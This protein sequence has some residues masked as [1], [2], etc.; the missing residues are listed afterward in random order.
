MS[1]EDTAPSVRA[2]T[3]TATSW[4]VKG[5]DVYFYFEAR[6]YRIRGLSSNHSLQQLRVNVLVRRDE[7]VH[8]DTF[9]L[10]KA[11][12]RASFI[13][14]VASELYA[15]EETIKRELGPILLQLEQLQLDQIEAA[16]AT[17]QVRIE[18]TDKQRR[19]AL[20]LLR[21]SRLT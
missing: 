2:E 4:E 5:E 17:E 10:Y 7:L 16:T 12:A 19:E 11:K 8:L 1:S 3:K 9:D 18:L 15:E 13:K 21:D 6:E 14:A 20:E